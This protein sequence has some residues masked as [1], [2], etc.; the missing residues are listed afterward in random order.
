M[1]DGL[2]LVFVGDRH[3][4]PY[5]LDR[6]LE[7][8]YTIPLVIGSDAVD[9]PNG[10]SL[11][12]ICDAH[13]IELLS[14]ADVEDADVLSKLRDA[15][16]TLGLCVGWTRILQGD[17]LDVPEFGFL[18]I[19]ASSLPRGRGGAPVNWAIIHG[20]DSVGVSLFEL[21]GEVDHGNV[22]AQTSVPIE[23]RDT[24]ETV[25]D[26]VI[27]ASIGLLER[28][29]TDLEGA[30]ETAE[31]QRFVDATYR[32]QRKPMD[33]LIDWNRPADGQH[34]WV[35]ALT[36]PYPGAFTF[37][38]GEKLKV[39]SLDDRGESTDGVDGE[40]LD[41]ADGRG[42]DVAS[43][44]GV[45]RLQ[46]VQGESLPATWADVYARRRDLSRGDVLGE[47]TDFPDWLY[48]GIRDADGGTRYRTNV[49]P[50]EGATYT[51]VSCSHKRPREVHIDATLSGEELV[52]TTLTVDGWTTQSIE[53]RPE[54]AG[55][56]TLTVSFTPRG[57]V[58]R[59]IR[60]LKLYVASGSD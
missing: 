25:Y 22:L 8:G 42:L 23:E 33:G 48:T 56:H 53:V 52:D 10:R 11:E 21:V 32:P 38:G 24:V 13:R 15:A 1:T 57:T 20:A 31:E 50:G 5:I 30:L 28:C 14:P 47:P 58:E 49:A 54:R 41:V 59:D 40:I 46:R 2:H 43:G 16:P 34:D 19:H 55:A 29:L 12:A 51:A 27:T 44:G 35:R 60:T 45:V 39:W 26:R 6:L 37:L 17:L 4:S 3:Y 18:G 9:R 7:M 36:K